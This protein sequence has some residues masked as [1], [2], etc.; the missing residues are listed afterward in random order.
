[1]AVIAARKAAISLVAGPFLSFAWAVGSWPARA[2]LPPVVQTTIPAKPGSATYTISTNKEKKWTGSQTVDMPGGVPL[3]FDLRALP[4]NVK[5]T[6]CA[7]R[8]VLAKGT[9]ALRSTGVLLE[10]DKADNAKAY[11]LAAA[12]AI[13]PRAAG[14]SV[15][16][17]TAAI[18]RSKGICDASAPGH[19]SVK[20]RLT[21]S[22]REVDLTIHGSKGNYDPTEQPAYAPR[23]IL[24]YKGV[25]LGDDSDW[26][27]MRRDAQHT[28]RSPWRVYD[29]DGRFTPDGFAVRAVASSADAAAL[30][31]P[32]AVRQSPLMYGGSLLWVDG[33]GA[34]YHV[35]RLGGDGAAHSSD[36]VA[37]APK[38]LAAGPPSSLYY[39]SANAITSY[40]I[41]GAVPKKDAVIVPLASV[42]MLVD[43]PTVGPDGSLYTVSNTQTETVVRG[44]AP[45]PMHAELWRS[46]L[47]LENAVSAVTLSEDG[48][49]AYVLLGGSANKLVALDA[50]T[51]DCRWQQTLPAG[52]KITPGGTPMAMPIPVVAGTN[53][54]VVDKFPI[55][56]DLFVFGDARTNEPSDAGETVAPVS[57]GA[58]GGTFSCRADKAPRITTML[59]V[60]GSPS[61]VVGVGGKAFYL[62][63]GAATQLC[64]WRG[65]GPKTSTCA[66]IDGDADCTSAAGNMERLIGDSS[67]GIANAKDEN[68]ATH[69]YGLDPRSN[70]LVLLTLRFQEPTAAETTMRVTCRSTELKDAGPNLILGRDGTL[71]NWNRGDKLQAIVP[72]G[73]SAS[74][75]HLELTPDLLYPGTDCASGGRNN[76]G[77]FRAAT[78]KTAPNL[79]VPRT[80]DIALVAG[81]GISFSSGLRIESG[82]RLRARVGF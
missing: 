48:T 64:W 52:K 65:S 22:A 49:T 30:I 4:P 15:E 2:E 24:T 12:Q 38:F 45:P 68:N 44:Y 75:G 77:V 5:P 34:S 66:K 26:G 43:A 37:D 71:Y 63:G 20:F 60:A 36:A 79:C 53:I 14:Q 16:Q 56:S 27:Q 31:G 33:Q 59:A 57:V 51:G 69:F 29:P 73:F 62:Q 13:E 76:G 70:R 67:G 32:V 11:P 41:S 78:I 39:A 8:V 25:G 47:A 35:E 61:P 58:T 50:A 46:R 28:G 9:G 19:T 21:T 40:D 55:G 54:M 80:A 42:E 18:F 3:E 7:V 1:M 6:S 17:G 23:L 81:S 10:L 82:A 74:A 72:S